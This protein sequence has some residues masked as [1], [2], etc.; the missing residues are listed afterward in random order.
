MNTPRSEKIHRLNYLAGELN[1]AYH[2]AA[3]KFGMADSALNVL[4]ALV[5][6]GG[7]CTL[8]DI[9]HSY[10]ISKQTVNS[11][12]RRLEKDGIIVLT[13]YRGKTKLV[14]LTEEGQRYVSNT[15]SKLYAAEASLLETW[16]EEEIRM[17]IALTEKYLSD[18]RARL[19]T[20]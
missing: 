15:V 16:T 5:D 2:Q 11:A 6:G 7:S 1:A 10:D 3:L 14:S 19:E 4:Y 20:L 9:Y 8:A 18:F 17:H 13:P 12:I